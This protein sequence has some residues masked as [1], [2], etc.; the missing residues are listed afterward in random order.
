MR[1]ERWGCQWWWFFSEWRGRGC[2]F[3]FT[4]SCELWVKTISSVLLRGARWLMVR[5]LYQ[6]INTPDV[7]RAIDNIIITALPLCNRS[8]TYENIIGV[9]PRNQHPRANINDN[10]RWSHPYHLHS[11]ICAS[12]FSKKAFE[13]IIEFRMYLSIYI[14]T[15]SYDLGLL[16]APFK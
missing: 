12:C 6:C 14:D 8:S 9:S 16:L 15:I 3:I 2:I 10:G 1:G 7:M 4:T 11:V 5:W 13:L